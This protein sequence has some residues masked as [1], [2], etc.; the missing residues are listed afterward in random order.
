ML[1]ISIQVGNRSIN[2]PPLNKGQSASLTDYEK[3][4]LLIFKEEEDFGYII[5]SKA[6]VHLEVE[7]KR[8]IDSFD[9]EIE[10]TLSNGETHKMPILTRYGAGILS[11][12]KDT[13]FMWQ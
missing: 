3:N 1:N 5:R 11:V 7:D 10:A 13:K 2:L 12:I 9:K 4:E 6:G 8:I